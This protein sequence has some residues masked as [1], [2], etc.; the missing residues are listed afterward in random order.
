MRHRRTD[1][2]CAYYKAPRPGSRKDRRSR[3]LACMV[4][5]PPWSPADRAAGAHLED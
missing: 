5:V 4:C 2:A 1:P 3:G